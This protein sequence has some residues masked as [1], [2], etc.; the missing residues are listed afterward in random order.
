MFASGG[1]ADKAATARQGDDP[2]RA[3]DM[4]RL[5]ATQRVNGSAGSYSAA[6]P[7]AQAGHRTYGGVAHN[8]LAHHTY[9]PRAPD[10]VGPAIPRT[11][12]FPRV[13]DM[14][15]ARLD[16]DRYMGATRVEEMER[17]AASWLD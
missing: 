14:D 5:D 1:L 6:A 17:Q 8:A 11:Q 9:H 3:A 15:A 10:L 7:L 4:Y 12:G 13:H 16:R 2:Q